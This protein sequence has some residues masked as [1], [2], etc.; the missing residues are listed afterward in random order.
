MPNWAYQEIHCK[1]KEDLE[2]IRNAFSA[3]PSDDNADIDFNKIIPM[4]KSIER[5]SS[6]SNFEAAA[7]FLMPEKTLPYEEIKLKID[8]FAK[9]LNNPMYK[10]LSDE[11]I[12]QL[13]KYRQNPENIK[14][15]TSKIIEP[16]STYVRNPF[17]EYCKEFELEPTIEN[18]G[19]Q[20]LYNYMMYSVCDWYNWSNNHWDTKWN[21]CDTI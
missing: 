9:T 14:S 5:T 4:P 13:I 17:L 1:N 11:K 10:M 12:K 6:P 8:E 20:M 3:N 7:F 21:A 16:A 2:R 19:K 18:Y 15:L